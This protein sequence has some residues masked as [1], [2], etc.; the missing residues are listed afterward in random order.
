VAES[1]ASLKARGIVRPSFIDELT[2]QHLA[3]HAG[4]YGTLIWV[5]MMLEQWMQKRMPDYSFP[6]DP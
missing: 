2:S 4:Y 3:A 1:L 5:L 6:A